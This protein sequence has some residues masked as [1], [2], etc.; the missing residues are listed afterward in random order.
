MTL[1]TT[2]ELQALVE[3]YV[4]E[5]DIAVRK[6]MINNIIFH[7]AGVQDI[8]P[9]SRK[10]SYFYDNPIKDARYLEALEVRI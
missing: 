9:E 1:D 2:G 5:T 3:Q 4:A 10:P 8:D 6:S 7:W